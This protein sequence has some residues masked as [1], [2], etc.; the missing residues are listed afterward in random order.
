MPTN[1]T[2]HRFKPILFSFSVE[3][4]KKTN[5]TEEVLGINNNNISSTVSQVETTT[6]SIDEVVPVQESVLQEEI[7]TASKVS[8]LKQKFQFGRKAF[9]KLA[10]SKGP[11]VTTSPSP[12]PS[13]STT[14]T[15]T[16][17]SNSS[18]FD[19]NTPPTPD[20]LLALAETSAKVF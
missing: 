18:S 20:V 6:V 7:G 11:E 5:V 12:P 16:P 14:T 8:S 9:G 15:T 17:S 4:K 1:V 3:K 2:C 10:G 19:P 13:S